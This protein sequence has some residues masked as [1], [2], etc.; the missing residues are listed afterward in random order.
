MFCFYTATSQVPSKE[1]VRQWMGPREQIKL[2][3]VLVF[4]SSVEKK[5]NRFQAF[6]VAVCT[7]R[8]HKMF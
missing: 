7:N 6:G 4:I 2:S 5:K 3:A 8:A 1:D